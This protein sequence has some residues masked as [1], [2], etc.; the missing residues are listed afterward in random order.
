M[1]IW[2]SFC[3]IPF[4]K[5]KF[6]NRRLD[7]G[8][9][10]MEVNIERIK[11]DIE[12]LN[13][14][15]QTPEKGCTRFSYTPEDRLARNYLIAEMQKIGLEVIID[16]IGNIR[17]RLAGSN[18]S[19]P[20][21]LVGSHLDTVR[22]GG[23]FDGVLGVVCGLEV[24][25]IIQENSILLNNPLEL[26]IFAEEEGCRFGV[27]MIGSKAMTGKLRLEDLKSLKDEEGN[28]LYDV[29][30]AFG[31]EPDRVEDCVIKPEQIK[32]MLELHVEQGAVLDIEGIPVGIVKAIAGFE[33]YIIE[34]EGTSNHAG[35]TPMQYR[36]DPLVAAAKVI[37]SIDELV[38]V[39]ANPTTVCTVGKILCEPNM[40]NVIPQKIIFTI[41]VRDVAEDGINIVVQEVKKKIE[42]VANEK[43]V[44]YNM[45]PLV[46]VPGVALSASIIKIIEESAM[47]R[48]ISYK[49]M[50]SGAGH[51]ASIMAEVTDVGMIFV[52]SVGGRSHAPEED[53]KYSDI[54]LGC[55]LFL[56][57]ILKL[58]TAR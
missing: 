9:S 35:A 47:E 6:S 26:V 34:L 53:T 52:P 56:D 13:K 27:S 38:K 15:N 14:F 55:N 54:E 32:A 18:P 19:A 37:G 17:G 7:M 3:F 8:G 16:P 42:E 5:C 20:A 1:P 24:L 36:R 58:T 43:S 39:K 45:K 22:N 29:A 46:K 2:H 25:R 51:D 12:E 48:K 31:L 57:T 4:K 28:S 33:R 41:D 21:V 40:P 49:L 44:R 23:K 11:K 50:N 30:K 10:C